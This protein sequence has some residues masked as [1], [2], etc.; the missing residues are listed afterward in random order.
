MNYFALLK[1]INA[2][3]KKGTEFSTKIVMV[4]IFMA[5]L[6]L[7]MFSGN[8]PQAIMLVLMEIGD[9]ICTI[10]VTF[11]ILYCICEGVEIA[12]E[13]Y[14]Q[15]VAEFKKADECT[16]DRECKCL[17]EPEAVSEEIKAQSA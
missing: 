16:C 2:A 9:I 11:M 10:T 7:F 8:M 4:M 5:G 12:K 15:Y 6:I 17:P 3:L 13:R 14:D 1:G